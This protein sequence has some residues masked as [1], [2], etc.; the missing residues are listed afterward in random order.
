MP[1]MN[2]DRSVLLAE[3]AA[4]EKRVSALEEKRGKSCSTEN[5][6][7]ARSIPKDEFTTQMMVH[8]IAHGFRATTFTRVPK[9]YYEWT[10]EK[11]RAVLSAYSTKHLTKSLVLRDHKHTG[12]HS[13]DAE[14]G[15]LVGAKYVCVV[16]QY[17]RKVDT[18]LLARVVG[19]AGKK[20]GAKCNFRLA[21]DCEGIT[22]YKPNAVAPLALRT[23][24]PVIV[25]KAISELPQGVFWLGG[26]EV[27]VKWRVEWKDFSRAFHPIIGRVS[28]PEEE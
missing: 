7:E 10:L 13:Y 17:G 4:L 11:R 14:I 15:G 8:A 19:E 27:D 21:E 22:G 26:G 6:Y 28:A 23:P 2:D 9:D 18:D 3:I 20:N 12:E 5:M 16:V 24:M 25:D 1:M